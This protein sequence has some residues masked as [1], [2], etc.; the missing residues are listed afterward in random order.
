MTSPNELLTALRVHLIEAEIV[1]HPDTVD[2]DLHPCFVEP[3]GGAPAPGDMTGAQ[4]DDK[5]ILSL[6]FSTTIAEGAFDTYR[7]RFAIDFRYRSRGTAGLKAGRDLDAAI[8]QE[9]INRPDFGYGYTLA[10]GESAQLFVLQASEFGAL[11]TLSMD[12]DDG[13]TE[14]AKYVFEV[15]AV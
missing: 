1:R 14:N 10:E 9:L 8:R 15:P 4:N 2:D 13:R 12:D 3:H 7:R 5:L 11:S 6:M